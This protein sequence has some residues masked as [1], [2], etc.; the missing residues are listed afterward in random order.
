MMNGFGVESIIAHNPMLLLL[1]RPLTP[2]L[3]NRHYVVTKVAHL[4]DS[5]CSV[6][7]KINNRMS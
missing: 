1:S 5:T 7:A 3:F 2:W 6:R 4:I